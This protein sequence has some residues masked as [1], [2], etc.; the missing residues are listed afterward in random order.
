ML[1][2]LAIWASRLLD[3]NNP[4]LLVE[5]RRNPWLSILIIGA[6]FLL[7]A[8]TFVIIPS[9]G[10]YLLSGMLLPLPAAMLVITVG[11]AMEFL[12]NYQMGHLWGQTLFLKLLDRLSTRFSKYEAF[13]RI[14]KTQQ[15]HQ[16]FTI[17]LLRSMPGP[18]NNVTSLFLGA[19]AIPFGMYMWSSLLGA[20]PKALTFTLS[21]VIL[22]QP[23]DPTLLLYALALIVPASFVIILFW[24]RQRNRKQEQDISLP[25]DRP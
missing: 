1:L 16:A 23:L 21:G 13:T 18:P 3:G 14:R 7:K 4:A 11:M 6:F 20:F 19:S 8:L 15:N 12:L 9:A 5:L 25:T 17:F 2:A 10:V 24:R 22:F